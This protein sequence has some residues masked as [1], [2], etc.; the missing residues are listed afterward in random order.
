MMKDDKNIAQMIFS[1]A[2]VTNIKRHM[3]VL[4]LTI[5]GVRAP[6]RAPSA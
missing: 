1:L 3:I 5:C 2:K 6:L 4:R